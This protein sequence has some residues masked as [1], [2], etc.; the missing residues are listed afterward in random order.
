MVSVILKEDKHVEVWVWGVT[1]EQNLA[2]KR[3]EDLGKIEKLKDTLGNRWGDDVRSVTCYV[4]KDGNDIC[5]DIDGKK[6][7]RPIT[8]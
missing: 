2:K 8:L 7:K 1:T 3:E 6:T 4:H 5:L